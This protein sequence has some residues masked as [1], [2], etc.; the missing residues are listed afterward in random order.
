[1]V[2]ADAPEGRRALASPLHYPGHACPFALARPRRPRRSRRRGRARRARNG[3]AFQ[4]RSVADHSRRS[5]RGRWRIGRGIVCDLPRRHRRGVGAVDAPGIVVERRVP[6]GVRDRAARFVQELSRAA[7]RGG[8]RARGDRRARRDHVCG[9]PRPRR[10]RARQRTLRWRA[11]RRRRVAGIR[12]E[13]ALRGLPPVRLPGRPRVAART[14]ADARADAGH[15]RGVGVERDR[16]RRSRLPRLSHACADRPGRP[17]PPQSRVSGQSGPRAPR[18][19]R[20]DRYRRR[21]VGR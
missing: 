19:S 14:A 20:L 3:R 7:S 2:H 10:S 18:A 1:M 11:A 6:G 8:R 9:L 5:A 4:P 21:A 15:V 17:A 16:G 12:N 13:R